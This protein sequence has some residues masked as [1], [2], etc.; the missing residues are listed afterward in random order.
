MPRQSINQSIDRS[1]IDCQIKKKETKF[2]R[3]NAYVRACM[4]GKHN[5]QTKKRILLHQRKK[6]DHNDHVYNRE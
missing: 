4:Y 5:E 3:F 6:N 2:K 1:F